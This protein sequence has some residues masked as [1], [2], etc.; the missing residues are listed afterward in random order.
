MHQALT[1]SAEQRKVLLYDHTHNILFDIYDI[2]DTNKDGYISQQEFKVYFQVMAPST[3]DKAVT[4]SFNVLDAN[5]D[6]K[7]SRGEFLTAA[8][9]FFLGLEETEVSRVFM[10]ELVD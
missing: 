10:G 2:Y 6:G 3:P 5:K 8:E 7:I 1:M 9:D 4:H